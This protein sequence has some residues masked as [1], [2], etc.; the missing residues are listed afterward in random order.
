MILEATIQAEKELGSVTHE[1]EAEKDNTIGN[2]GNEDTA[3]IDRMVEELGK[4]FQVQK[5]F[6]WIAIWKI[7]M[8]YGMNLLLWITAVS[9]LQKWTVFKSKKEKSLFLGKEEWQYNEMFWSE[10]YGGYFV[11]KLVKS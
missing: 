6:I 11:Q 5:S 8:T 1:E 2:E 4:S 9:I 7:Q 10:I 3:V